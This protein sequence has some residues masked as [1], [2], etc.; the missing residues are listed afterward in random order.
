ML[1]MPY[2]SIK[3]RISTFFMKMKVKY[4]YMLVQYLWKSTQT[5]LTVALDNVSV[6][7]CKCLVY[8]F[9]TWINGQCERDVLMVGRAL[10]LVPAA[11]YIYS[12]SFSAVLLFFLNLH[13]LPGCRGLRLPVELL[14]SS[15][16]VNA[17]AAEE[18]AAQHHQD[19]SRPPYKEGGAKLIPERQRFHAFI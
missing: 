14:S 2:I 18:R 9:W 8:V 4:I 6:C 5:S 11:L 16:L 10:S 3:Y 17:G 7:P 15:V 19:G 12:F 1:G 13:V